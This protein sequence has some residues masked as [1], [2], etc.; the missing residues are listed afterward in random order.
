MS[1]WQM[2]SGR[3]PPLM[4]SI[5]KVSPSTDEDREAFPRYLGRS[6]SMEEG[7]Y[8]MLEGSARGSAWAVDPCGER[9]RSAC[10][11]A[12]ATGARLPDRVAV[13]WPAGSPL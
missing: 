5:S 1:T 13:S 11:F 9:G 2:F 8:M 3:N 12:P 10:V 7:H 6:A 4:G